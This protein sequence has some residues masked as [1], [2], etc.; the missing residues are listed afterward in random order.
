LKIKRIAAL[1]AVVSVSALVLAG[2]APA[3]DTPKSEIKAG[4]AVSIAQNSAFTSYNPAAAADNSTYNSNVT[5][6]TNASFNYYDNSP[7][8]VK[9]TKFGTYTK[10]SDD[11]LT[12]KY[13]I[14]KGVKWSDGSKVDAADMLL[15][16]A[17]TQ[18]K[19][20]AKDV[21]FGA[22]GAGAVGSVTQVPKISDG[23]QSVTLVY[24]KP[25]VDWETAFTP[26]VPAHVTYDLAFP[27]EKLS[28][29]KA[30]A[31]VI[32]AIQD[33][34]TTKM[35][36]IAKAWGT[37]YAMVDM[38]SNKNL[39][40]SDGAY[41]ITNLVKDQYVTLKANPKYTWGPLPKVQKITIR[42]IQD[43]TAQVQALENGEVGIISGQAT[44]DTVAALAKIKGIT[45]T[46][47]NNATYE[48]L[49]LT[50]NNKGGVFNPATY[51][52][53]A[54]KALA[55][56]QAFLKTIPR[57]DIVDTLIK[58]LSSS[59]TLDDSQTFL[60]GAPGYD[61]SIKS[62]GSAA[63][64]TVDIAGAQDLLKQAGV[65]SP[66]VKIVYPNDN[67][68]RANEFQLIQ[69]SAKKAGFNIVDGGVPTAKY[70]ADGFLGSGQYDASIFAWQF[71][72]LAATGSEAQ[73][74]TGNPGT[75]NY[76]GYS[77]AS[78]DS[79]FAA[80]EQETDKAKQIALLQ[81]IDKTTWADA[82]G[83]TLYQLPDVS[84]WSSKIKNVSDAPLS[85]NI[86]W[87]YWQ[88]DVTQ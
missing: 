50:F 31:A 57:Q 33:N 15:A 24:D 26:G 44:A 20:N 7:K 37:G 1:A 52:G 66:K 6:L 85:P 76:S 21:S 49:D 83:V 18:T 75:G 46:T 70:F 55:V 54:A 67:P 69:A 23:G 5:Y 40:L 78:V 84:A 86:F 32:K 43:P 77:N 60:P 27:D 14:N 53:D 63:Y 17:S 8:L 36:A 58:P 82:Y 47:T 25:F 64:K 39:V 13:T 62:N 65:K 10:V 11:P 30:K 61:D 72:S 73:L 9:N 88:W 12:I 48:H 35:A 42:F 51:G 45:T 3:D 74:K 29:T 19:W 59:A 4:T 71:T 28:P 16:W 87:N 81:N 80:L 22:A 38:P 79:D 41:I 68:R 34:D 56:R 2:C